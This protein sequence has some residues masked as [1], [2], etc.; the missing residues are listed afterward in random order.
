MNT[1]PKFTD[2]QMVNLV[3]NALLVA[4]EELGENG[5]HWPVIKSTIHSIM[6][7]WEDVQIERNVQAEMK[8]H[9]YAQLAEMER[10]LPTCPPDVQTDAAPKIKE[11]REIYDAYF[12][13][14]AQDNY[15]ESEIPAHIKRA[16]AIIHTM[17][18][19]DE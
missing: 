11:L 6:K 1:A 12:T 3:R 9:L 5:D 10:L 16:R 15:D 14:V 19:D 17:E 7:D 4:G 8:K 18:V 2:A 13:P